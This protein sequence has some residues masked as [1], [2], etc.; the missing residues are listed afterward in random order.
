MNVIGTLRLLKIMYNDA[1]INEKEFTKA[2]K[3]LKHHGF[4]ISDDIID[5][6]K[7]IRRTYKNTLD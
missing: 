3:D 2:I 4:R 7:S 6:V 5:K 1:L